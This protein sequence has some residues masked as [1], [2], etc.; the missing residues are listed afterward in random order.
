MDNRTEQLADGVWRAEIGYYVNAFV[1]AN[2]G[3]GDGGGLTLVDTGRAP[4]GARLVR[5][6]RMLGLDPRTITD[7][8]LTHW[9]RNHA[10]SAAAFHRS[11]AAPRV[12]VGLRDLPILR[13]D[14]EPA[15][16]LPPGGASAAGRRLTRAGLIGR[17]A[18]V[19]QA[20]SISGGDR[21]EV[22]GGLDVV[23][24]PGHTPGGCAFLL[25]ERGVLLAGDA[26]CNVW[27]LSRGPR[28]V[29]SKVP[30][31]PA[32]LR[33]LAG[34]DFGVLAVGHG[35]PVIARAR[36]RLAGLAERGD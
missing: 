3:R 25:P 22:A 1:L 28:L 20:E 24:A 11:S 19:P 14:V 15:D 35:P 26:A 23:E 9:H 27:F 13:G 18:P 16:A 12:R 4:H 30:S 7:V 10:G 8:L 2:D 36:E 5:S 34:L 31:V 29:C 6:V 32:T 21:L 33:Y 17:P